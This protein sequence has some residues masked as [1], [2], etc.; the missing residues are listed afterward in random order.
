[1]KI[2]EDFWEQL[3]KDKKAEEFFKSLNRANIYAIGWRLQTAKQ[4][5]IRTKRMNQLLEML[6]RGEKLH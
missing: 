1:M 6:K 3:A 2:P 4:S 5:E